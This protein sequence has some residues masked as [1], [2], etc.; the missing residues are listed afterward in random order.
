MKRCYIYNYSKIYF[1]KED[2]EAYGQVCKEG[3]KGI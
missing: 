3:V 1:Q 2:T